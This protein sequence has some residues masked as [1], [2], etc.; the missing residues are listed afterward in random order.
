VSAATQQFQAPAR[1]HVSAA[2]Q[3]MQAPARVA[4]SG[5]ARQARR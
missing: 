2:P 3:H 5:S 1:A 4:A